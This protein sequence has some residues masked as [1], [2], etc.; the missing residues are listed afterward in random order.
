MVDIALFFVGDRIQYIDLC[1]TFRQ[2][3]QYRHFKVILCCL[4][5]GWAYSSVSIYRDTRLLPYSRS[6]EMSTS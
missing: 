3:G 6:V 1:V 5:L 2:C 4:H